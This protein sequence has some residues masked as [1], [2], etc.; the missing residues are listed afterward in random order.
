MSRRLAIEAV[1]NAKKWNDKKPDGVDLKPARGS[2]GYYPKERHRCPL[3]R[4]NVAAYRLPCSHFI[5]VDA[6]HEILAASA[7]DT[8]RPVIV[9]PTCKDAE[10][11]ACKCMDCDGFRPFSWECPRCLSP[12]CAACLDGAVFCNQCC[13]EFPKA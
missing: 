1:E 13:A 8:A 7:Y 3:Q 11:V 6:A 12:R 4:V 10:P 5:G 9:C 2:L